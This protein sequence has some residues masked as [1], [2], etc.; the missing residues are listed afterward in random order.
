MSK[1]KKGKNKNMGVGD[2]I[3]CEADMGYAEMEGYLGEVCD[4]FVRMGIGG[5]RVAELIG[6]KYRRDHDDLGYLRN[7]GTALR[8]VNVNASNN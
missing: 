2:G 4:R 8:N 7:I 1:F 3:N 5:V 6:K